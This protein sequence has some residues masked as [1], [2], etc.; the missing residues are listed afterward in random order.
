MAQLQG[1]PLQYTRPGAAG[2]LAALSCAVRRAAAAILL[3]ALLGLGAVTPSRAAAPALTIYFIDVEGGQSTLVV[4]P[5]HQALLVDAGYPGRN[6]RDIDRVMAAARDAGVTRLDY[7]LITHYHQ[8]HVGGVAEVSRRLPV[9]TFVDHGTPV[10]SDPIYAEPDRMA[11]AA[12]VDAAKGHT[13]LHALPGDRLKLKGLDVIITNG[14]GETLAKAVPGGGQVNP[15]CADYTPIADDPGENAN[16]LGLW[17]RFGK[18]RFADPGDLNYNKLG[19]LACP[20][21]L[22][23]PVDAYLVSHHGNLDS[24]VPAFVEGLHPRAAII[25]NGERKGGAPATFDTLRRMPFLE[26]RW[27]LHSSVN[28]GVENFPVEGIANLDTQTAHWLK[29]R[30]TRD[31]GFT[32]ENP[33]TGSTVTYRAPR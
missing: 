16:S 15:A 4:T 5:E 14:G 23:G 29:L 13:Q 1:V 8:D 18:F 9:G 33:R 28:E 27:Q 32:V 12:Y 11:Y 7:L 26:G 2:R 22:V 30:A 31:G 21:N 10:D 17:L 3:A 6:D 24:N 25:N 20:L 19:Q